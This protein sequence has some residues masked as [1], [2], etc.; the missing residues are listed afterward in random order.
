MADTIII[1]SQIPDLVSQD[2]LKIFDDSLKSKPPVFSNIYDVQSSKHKYEKIS[3]VT[4]LPLLAAKDEGAEPGNGSLKQKYDKEYLH[5]TYA[6]TTRITR[7][8]FDD[9]L[10]GQLR[11]IPMLQAVSA[12][13]T[14]ENTAA[15]VFDRSQNG[16]YLGPDGKVLCA[17]DHPRA[18]GGTWSNRPSSNA[19]LGVT[20]LEAALSAMRRTVDDYGNPMG[21]M[22][23]M[24]LLPPEGEWQAIQLL[25]N[26]EKSN[27]ASRDINAIKTRGLAYLIWDNL[28]DDDSWYILTPKQQRQLIFF[29]REKIGTSVYSAPDNTLDAV[30]QVR[31]RFS[32]GWVDARGI[33]G[34]IG[35]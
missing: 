35:A 33:Y 11:K 16:S 20:V 27:T 8:A 21:T 31:C 34:S 15:A 30:H 19:D 6:L 17:T 25:K 22:P 4:G 14:V 32:L 29:W 24:L 18:D 5:T 13:E 9:D 7:E 28:T 23:D 26:A 10:S 2:F 3:G 1:R 12:R